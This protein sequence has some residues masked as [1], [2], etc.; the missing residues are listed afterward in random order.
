[1]HYIVDV[2]EAFNL[3]LLVLSISLPYTHT[4]TLYLYLVI[5]FLYARLHTPHSDV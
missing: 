4:H 2:L 5:S 1:M 3:V